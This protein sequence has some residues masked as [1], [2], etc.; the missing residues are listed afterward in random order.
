MIEQTQCTT[1]DPVEGAHEML[2]DSVDL[3]TKLPCAAI[4]SKDRPVTK[5]VICAQNNK[6]RMIGGRESEKR[7]GAMDLWVPG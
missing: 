2:V 7:K 1:D 4:I 6:C 5:Q 3:Q